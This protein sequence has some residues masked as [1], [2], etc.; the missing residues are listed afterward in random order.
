MTDAAV[1]KAMRFQVAGQ[2]PDGGWMGPLGRSDPAI[3]ALIAQTFIQHPA[4]GLDHQVVRKALDFVLKFEQPDG[5]IYDPELGYHNYSTSVAVM[6]LAAADRPDLR[7]RMLAARAWLVNNQWVEGKL[8]KNGKPIDPAHAWYG[9][10]GYGRHQRPDLSNTQMMLDA[11]VAGGLGAEHPA[12]AKALRFVERC[13]MREASNDQPFAVGV[14]NGG[15]VYTPAEGGASMADTVEV[16]G[17][18]QLRSYGSMTYAGFKSMIYARVGRDDPRVL[19][20]LNWI[21]GHYTL[22]SNPNMPGAKSRDGLFYYYQVFAKA[23]E[24]W[25]EPLLVDRSVPPTTGGR[26]CAAPCW[27]PSSPTAV[28]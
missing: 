22:S 9:G 1:E 10:A 15:F 20:A 26:S 19:A 5:G 4:Y 14:D 7:E 18:V 13:Q 27:P 11:L 8:D 17:R 28:G 12:Y 6:M 21:R 2:Q 23:L 24:A 25:G 3:T 16:D